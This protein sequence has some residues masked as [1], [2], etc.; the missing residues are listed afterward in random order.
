LGARFWPADSPSIWPRFGF[1]SR[2]VSFRFS[3]SGIYNPNIVLVGCPFYQCRIGFA[4]LKLFKTFT[5]MRLGSFVH[6]VGVSVRRQSGRAWCIGYTSVVDS[7]RSP[8]G[9][10]FLPVGNEPHRVEASSTGI[11]TED[12]TDVTP[13][14][15]SY[16]GPHV[17]LISPP[18]S[19]S[20]TPEDTS[21]HPSRGS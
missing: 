18:R 3:I 10:V 7:C 20:L 1:V 15:G 19:S 6:E 8:F 12:W 9:P 13:F 4:D 5:R 2:M 16:N 11:W 14:Q 17:A 21:R